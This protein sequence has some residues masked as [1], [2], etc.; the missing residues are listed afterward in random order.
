MIKAELM[1][2]ANITA[3]APL[4]KQARN[5]GITNFAELR[6]YVRAIPYGRTSNRGDLSLVFHENCGTC[7]SKHALVKAIAGENDIADLKLIIGMYKMTKQNTPNIGDVIE[8]SPLSYIP[9]AHCYLKY[10]GQR[11]DITAAD[12]NFERI[13]ADLLEEQTIQPLQIGSYKVN[14]HQQYLKDWIK[15]EEIPLT[16]E[17]VWAIREACIKNLSN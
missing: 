1:W 15:K 3:N 16:F 14:Y 7:S 9:E 4:S 8:N 10:A 12:A 13:Q 5:I 6:D 17:Q 11:I 2:V